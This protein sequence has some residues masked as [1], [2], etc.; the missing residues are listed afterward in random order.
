MIF[1]G[2]IFGLGFI[3]VRSRRDD[4]WNGSFLLV[5]AVVRLSG[6]LGVMDGWMNMGG[7]ADLW[8]THM[9]GNSWRILS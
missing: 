9:Y 8:T 4:R 6:V 2:V 1:G 3:N 5:V 7:W